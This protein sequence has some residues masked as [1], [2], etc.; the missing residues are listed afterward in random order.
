[1]IKSKEPKYTEIVMSDREFKELYL[2][3]QNNFKF[4]DRVRHEYSDLLSSSDIVIA[5]GFT[6]PGAEGLLLSKR[7]IYYNELKYGGQAYNKIP[8][9]IARN[10]DE[11][12]TLFEKSLYDYNK[13]ADVISDSLNGLDPFRD[14]QALRRIS[15]IIIEG[16]K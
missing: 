4:S 16:V 13:Y 3:A 9:L 15:K 12:S 10:N 8:D 14:A 11:L 1:V 6:T 2:Q 5:M 7:V